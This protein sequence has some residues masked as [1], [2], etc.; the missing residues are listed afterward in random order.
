LLTNNRFDSLKLNSP[1]AKVVGDFFYPESYPEFISGSFYAIFLK[2]L[3]IYFRSHSRPSLQAI[4]LQT[5]FLAAA[6]SFLWSLCHHQKKVVFN[7]HRLSTAVGAR[8]F[9]INNFVCDFPSYPALKEYILENN[10]ITIF[11]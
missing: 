7:R 6:R 2:D 1:I 3:S 10:C 4:G 11:S 9:A 5:L 8:D